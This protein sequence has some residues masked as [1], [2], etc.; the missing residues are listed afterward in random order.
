MGVP[1]LPGTPSLIDLLMSTLLKTLRE[2]L[3]PTGVGGG[4]GQLGKRCGMLPHL[5]RVHS[6]SASAHLDVSSPAKTLICK[7]VS[8]EHPWAVAEHHENGPD[9]KPVRCA[10]HDGNPCFKKQPHLTLPSGTDTAVYCV[11]KISPWGSSFPG[12]FLMR[13]ARGSG[14]SRRALPPGSP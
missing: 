2:R 14:C 10:V 8:S 3:E 13:F 6:L 12:L 9:H 1:S 7:L 5:S 11:R 4:E